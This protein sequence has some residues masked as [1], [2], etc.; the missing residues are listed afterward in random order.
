MKFGHNHSDLENIS[1]KEEKI[2]IS[3]LLVKSKAIYLCT[4]IEVK[5][6]II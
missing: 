2:L 4:K 6:R 5:G 3:M 1:S